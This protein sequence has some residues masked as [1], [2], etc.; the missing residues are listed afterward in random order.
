MGN[1]QAPSFE[2]TAPTFFTYALPKRFPPFRVAILVGQ[3]SVNQSQ[4]GSHLTL[5]QPTY[6]TALCEKIMPRVHVD[7]GFAFL[8]N[9]E[10][11][12]NDAHTIDNVVSHKL[13]L[14]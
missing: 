14:K 3:K 12:S 4:A 6:Q 9:R 7:R 2:A 11:R 1:L 5:L 8:T 13:V 10:P